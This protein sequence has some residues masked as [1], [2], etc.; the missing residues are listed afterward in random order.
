MINTNNELKPFVSLK[1][2]ND[3]M[4]VE[5]EVTPG[6]KDSSTVEDPQLRAQLE[7][8][9]KKISLKRKEIDYYDDRI[10]NLTDQGDSLDHAIAAGS[11][12]L[13]AILDIVF[14]DGVTIQSG[15]LH[16]AKAEPTG[17]LANTLASAVSTSGGKVSSSSLAQ[18]IILHTVLWGLGLVGAPL[19]GLPTPIAS[20]M[21]SASASNAIT[22]LTSGKNMSGVSTYL[23]QAAGNNTIN[24]SKGLDTLALVGKQ[25]LP[26]LLNECIVR[27]FY[28]L[29]RF[30]REVNDKDITSPSEL[31]RIDWDNT[32]PFKNR[33]IVRMMTIATAIF[34]AID[35][36]AATIEGVVV[37]A[38][39][40]T[41]FFNKFLLS[42][43]FVGIGRM[44]IACGTDLIMGYMQKKDRDNRAVLIDEMIRLENIKMSYKQKDIWVKAKNA[45]EVINESYAMM[46]EAQDAFVKGYYENKQDLSHI[47]ANA[48]KIEEKNPGLEDDIRNIIHWE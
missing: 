16:I 22:K 3:D 2:E 42:V 23:T 38:G 39:N 29:R 6:L 15:A 13:A 17:K 9:E 43:N 34:S 1:A 35:V 28:F 48:S 4:N 36:A 21:K 10:Y 12:V 5:V 40:A 26:V 37:S 44:V 8:V 19:V 20:F 30:F 47:G 14:V 46:S 31:Y 24:F 41:A 25:A 11:G 45:E 27:A 7:T 32:I 18:N 33:T